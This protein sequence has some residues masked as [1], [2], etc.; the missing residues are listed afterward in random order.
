MYTEDDRREPEYDEY[1]HED[2]EPEVERGL[3]PVASVPGKNIL[4]MVI[5]VAIVVV[6]IYYSFFAETPEEVAKKA[7]PPPPVISKE[8][9]TKPVSPD[10]EGQI[11]TV[12]PSLPEPPPLVVP[13]PPVP[14]APVAPA[15]PAAPVPAA[16]LPAATAVPQ[17]PFIKNDDAKKLAAEEARRKEAEA[18]EATRIARRKS[19][20]MAG[21]GGGGGG[22][23]G[24]TKSLTGGLDANFEPTI[25][26]S[27]QA[28]A[29][30]IGNRESI[31]AQGKVIDAVLETAINTDLP[32]LLRA[33]VS[34][35]VYAEAG[36]T[37]LIPKGSRL[38]GNYQADVRRGQRRVNIIWA[39]V[40]R[41]DGIDIAI[42]S[43]AS[44]Q[45]GRA[46]VDGKVDNRYME[47]FSSAILLSTISTGFAIIAENT[48]GGNNASTTSTTTG[49]GGSTT[50]TT[51]TPTGNA[52]A[53]GVSQVGNI[54]QGI[55]QDYL[56]IK[57]TITVDQGT[58]II[59]YVNRDLVFPATI[60]N[61]I[62]LVE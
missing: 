14:V 28:R 38:I 39:R 50:S 9:T 34:R 13:T 11:T 24:A 8:A 17:V 29:T 44:D 43:P 7:P 41:P 32:G 59:V 61:N 45:L 16:P 49:A 3:S 4:I 20:M 26:A 46:G 51:A 37:I 40:I 55:T 5:L 31:I 53:S 19:S 23:G 10:T 12:M 56:E 15:A 57:P 60:S 25:T 1:G 18:R 27:P 21:G 47:L 33:V 42:D 52:I 6:A 36:R 48:A 2:I 62:Q 22:G 35:D 30:M 58:K 54:A